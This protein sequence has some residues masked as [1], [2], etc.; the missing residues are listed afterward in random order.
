MAV[1]VGGGGL[2][3]DHMS[4]FWAHKRLEHEAGIIELVARECSSRLQIDLEID[5]Y[6][7]IDGQ[8]SVSKLKNF[9]FC[10]GGGTGYDTFARITAP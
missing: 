2:H 8:A 3:G 9:Q 10:I 5:T 6:L 1:N 7:R 4:I